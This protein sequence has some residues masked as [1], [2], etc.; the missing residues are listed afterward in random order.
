MVEGDERQQSGR[1]KSPFSGGKDC[2][3]YF[4]VPMYDSWCR[5]WTESAVRCRKFSYLYNTTLEN[6]IVQKSILPILHIHCI[7]KIPHRYLYHHDS[8]EVRSIV[9]PFN[10][11]ERARSQT[12]LARLGD[13][14]AWHSFS[15]PPEAIGVGGSSAPSSIPD[16]TG[17]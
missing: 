1:V 10:S 8:S 16:L 2:W 14:N 3:F 11:G 5:I 12:G 4:H 6:S 17:V 15:S 7:A 9:T 13:V